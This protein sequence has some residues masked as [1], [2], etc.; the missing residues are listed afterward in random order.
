MELEYTEEIASDNSASPRKR[1][2]NIPS[3]NLDASENMGSDAPVDKKKPKVPLM[4][5]SALKNTEEND[6]RLSDEQ[7]SE[8]LKHPSDNSTGSRPK[9]NVPKIPMEGLGSRD[10]GEVTSFKKP[11]GLSLVY[12]ILIVCLFVLCS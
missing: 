1:P 8:R 3:L 9:F 11:M 12:I 5:F 10:E 6:E 7:R 2:F 4:N